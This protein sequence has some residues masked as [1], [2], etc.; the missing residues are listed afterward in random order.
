MNR[1]DRSNQS[2]NERLYTEEA[3]M[4]IDVLVSDVLGSCSFWA[5]VVA[6]G[7]ESDGHDLG[8][9]RLGLPP[10]LSPSFGFGRFNVYFCV[11]VAR[12]C[13][14]SLFY[15][16]V[17]VRHFPFFYFVVLHFLFLPISHQRCYYPLLPMSYIN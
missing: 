1:G 10:S 14:S 5:V 2:V 13:L 15:D 6:H 3:Y 4:D 9:I 11:S 8:L 17:Y 7:V 16:K 12:A